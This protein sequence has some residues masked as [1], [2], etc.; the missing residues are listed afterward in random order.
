MYVSRDRHTTFP[1]VYPP[2]PAG[3]DMKSGAE[4]M[5]AAAA[6][7]LAAGITVNVTGRDA[8]GEASDRGLERRFGRPARRRS[9][10]GSA[11]S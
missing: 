4:K 11:R 6:A 1:E 8:L 5:R 9:S 2:G 3:L 10:A 7:G